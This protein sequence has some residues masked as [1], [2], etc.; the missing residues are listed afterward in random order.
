MKKIKCSWGIFAHN[1][2]KNIAKLLEAALEQELKEVAIGEILVVASGCT[3]RTVVLAKEFEQKDQRIKV[4]VQEKREGKYSAINLFL[5]QARSDILVIESADTLPQKNTIEQLIGVFKDPQ[6]GMAGVR[7]MPVD[8]P[9]TFLG[10]STY[11]LWELHH[12]IA[13]KSPKMGE[14]VA[15]RRVLEKLEATAVDE[16]FIE[17]VV[18]VGGYRVV[19]APEAIVYNKGPETIRDFLRQRR[20]IF[21]GHLALKKQAGYRVATLSPAKETLGFILRHDFTVKQMLFVLGTIA[22]EIWGRF[23]GWWD[24]KIKKTNHV[25]WE[26]ATTTRDLNHGK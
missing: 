22:L 24:F 4:L 7:P 26:M 18:K 2:E 20:R 17:G 16:A 6:V 5:K 19:Y 21:A 1:E 23:L 12:Q 3:D 13:L 9:K 11:L 25:I 15:F 8:S 10:F 14:M